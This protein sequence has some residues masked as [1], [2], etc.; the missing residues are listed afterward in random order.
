MGTVSVPAAVRM[1]SVRAAA[2]PAERAFDRELR[3][4][5]AH[6]PEPGLVRVRTE[7]LVL[8]VVYVLGVIVLF[9]LVGLVAKAVEKL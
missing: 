5:S 4:T 6:G 7:S 9:V 2:G 8:D 1:Q 3:R